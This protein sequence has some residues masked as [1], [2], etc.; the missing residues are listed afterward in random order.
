M[1]FTIDDIKRWQSYGFVLTPVRD[2]KPVGDTWIKDVK[3]DDPEGPV[4]A[5]ADEARNYEFDAEGNPIREVPAN[6]TMD[7]LRGEYENLGRI[8]SYE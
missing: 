4:G 2:K 1:S 6:K 8:P 5:W 3:G 7:R